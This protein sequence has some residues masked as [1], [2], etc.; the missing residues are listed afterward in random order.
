LTQRE[1]K[2][3]S[4]RQRQR[5]WQAEAEGEA[6]SPQSRGSLMWDSIP[7]PWDHDLSRRQTLSRLSHPGTPTEGF[8]KG[9]V[10]VAL[11]ESPGLMAVILVERKIHRGIPT[12]PPLMFSV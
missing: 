3:G 9:S 8:L 2:Q 11:G 5:E 6:G 12:A 10:L 4:G 1:H 7:G